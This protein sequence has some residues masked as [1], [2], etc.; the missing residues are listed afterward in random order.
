MFTT[1]YTLLISCQNGGDP[2]QGA[3]NW[4]LRGAKNTLWEGGTR[5]KG[6]VYST[7]LFKKTGTV[8]NG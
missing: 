3:S 5:G 6:L 2:T 7:N 1:E 8:Y 4:P